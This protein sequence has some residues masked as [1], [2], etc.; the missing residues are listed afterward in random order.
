MASH[1]GNTR[2]KSSSPLRG[3]ILRLRRGESVVTVLTEALGETLTA[4]L[5]EVWR[6]AKLWTC[7]GTP[8]GR[9]ARDGRRISGRRTSRVKFRAR[10]TTATQADHPEVRAQAEFFLRIVER[11][12][13]SGRVWHKALWLPELARRIGRSRKQCSRYL[14]ALRSAGIL[15]SWQPPVNGETPAPCKTRKGRAYNCY[16]LLVDVPRRLLEHVHAWLGMAGDKTPPQIAT[17]TATRRPVGSGAAY[18]LEWLHR[19]DG[20]PERS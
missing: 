19:Q 13:E 3:F 5:I 20:P 1:Y 8:T 16:Q 11:M 15:N 14:G 7:R 4:Q 2:P 17:E 12:R 9:L 6:H 18:F 10:G